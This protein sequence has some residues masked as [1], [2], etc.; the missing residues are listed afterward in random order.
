MAAQSHA[1]HRLGREVS[2]TTRTACGLGEAPV[3]SAETATC[4]GQ[5]SAPGLLIAKHE[6]PPNCAKSHGLC[7]PEP[8]HGT[9]T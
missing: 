5:A 3:A 7:L 6:S 9:V 4:H 2:H 8:H 1:C